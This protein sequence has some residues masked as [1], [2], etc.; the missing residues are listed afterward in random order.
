[1]EKRDHWLD[2]LD[3]EP[4]SLDVDAAL[5]RVRQAPGRRT[6][7]SGWRWPAA[8]LALAATV[9][10]GQQALSL[11]EVRQVLVLKYPVGELPMELML[12]NVFPFYP[13]N[14]IQRWR[15]SSAA[16]ASAQAGFRARQLRSTHVPHQP[17]FTV[18]QYPAVE[19]RIDGRAIAAALAKRSSAPIPIPAGLDGGLVTV[20]ASGRALIS[21]YGNCPRLV[22]PWDACAMLIQTNPPVIELPTGVDHAAYVE[23]SLRLV[24]ISAGDAQTFLRMSHQAPTLFL[25]L[26]EEVLDFST[27]AL[28]SGSG[29]LM[30]YAPAA[31]GTAFALEWARDGQRFM[32]MGRD[33]ARAVELANSLD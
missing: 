17:R 21:R 32:L 15:P 26:S 10:I 12:P 28:K 7:R 11:F 5:A 33:P 24:G 30:R 20:R 19:R 6:A 16:E 8:G 9:L 13:M 25:P 1:M 4:R 22:G 14:E 23:F 27:V 3:D 18:E 29:L 2:V 31:N